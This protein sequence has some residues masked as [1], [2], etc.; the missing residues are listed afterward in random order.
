MVYLWAVDCPI[1]TLT[2]LLLVRIQFPIFQFFFD[3]VLIAFFIHKVCIIFFLPCC[4]LACCFIFEVTLYLVRV[5]FFE[6]F[7]SNLSNLLAERCERNM[8]RC[9]ARSCVFV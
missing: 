7:L 3:C 1:V 8:R 5:L 6:G 4:F 9:F 2:L